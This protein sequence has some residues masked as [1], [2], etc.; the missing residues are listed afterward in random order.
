M[1]S[2]ARFAAANKT[3]GPRRKLRCFLFCFVISKWFIRNYWSCMIKL[4]FFLDEKRLY[5]QAFC[6]FHVPWG[7][8]SSWIFSILSYMM[9]RGLIVLSPL[10]KESEHQLGADADSSRA[11]DMEGRGPAVQADWPLCLLLALFTLYVYAEI[12]FI[13]IFMLMCYERKILFVDW[14]IIQANKVSRQLKCFTRLNF[15]TRIQNP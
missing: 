6:L 3:N 10:Y 8:W 12:W 5:H 7:F 9:P 11:T 13:L 2:I 1:A 15:S 4:S 14:K